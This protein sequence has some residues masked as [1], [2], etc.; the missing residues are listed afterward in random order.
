MSNREQDSS[1]WWSR[2]DGDPWSAPG[3][4]PAVIG[5]DGGFAPTRPTWGYPGDAV[6]GRNRRQ[7]PRWLVPGAAVVAVALA[8]GGV[9][10]WV[11]AT[12]ADGSSSGH[13]SVTLG[14]PPPAN[15]NTPARPAGSVAAVAKALLPSVVSIEVHTGSGGDTG[16]GIVLT[17]DGYILT[18]NHVISAAADGGGT[19]TVQL[20]T[21][22]GVPIAAK[23]I[24][25]DPES[26]LAVVKAAATGLQPGT[27]GNSDSLAVG[28]PVFAIGSPLGLSSTVTSGIVSALQ[29]P[30]SAS[31]EGSDT[32]AVIDAIQTDAP[33]NPGNSGGPLVAENGRVVGINSAIATLGS[34]T[35]FG[36]SS[37]SGSIGLGFAIPVNYARGIAEQLIRTG[38]AV[39]PLIK[40]KVSDPPRC[41]APNDAVATTSNRDGALICGVISGGPAERAGLHPGDLVVAFDDQAVT[42]ADQLVALTRIQRIG[43]KHSVSVIRAGRELRLVVQLGSDANS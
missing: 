32:N 42:S 33:I 12:I 6:D 40:A 13:T 11:G 28:D 15:A 17:S 3:A 22:P 26:D 31:G 14:A 8:A 35:N 9:G 21:K 19:I 27:L 4:G 34:N 10:G 29:R 20:Y 39:H 7:R 5:G 2:P 36:G 43:S 37:Q 1:A 38:H 41:P 23:I 16:S 25:R 18:N 24:G 30:V